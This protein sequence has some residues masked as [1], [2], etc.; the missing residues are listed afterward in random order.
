VLPVYYENLRNTSW[1]SFNLGRE[2][3][4]G[5]GELGVGWD[6]GAEVG[7]RFF[8]ESLGLFAGGGPS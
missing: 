4:G 7:E 3:F 8:T 5:G 6:L 2:V 1:G